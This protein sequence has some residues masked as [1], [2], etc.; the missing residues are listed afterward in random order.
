MGVALE[1]APEEGA[2]RAQDH[3]VRV[4]LIVLARQGH[5]E[6]LTLVPNITK[7]DAYVA[8][9]VVPFQAKLFGRHFDKVSSLI[10]H[11][12]LIHIVLTLLYLV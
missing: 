12:Y 9:E 5:V 4:N 11:F 1:D 10:A 2:A 8:L 7:C 3:F 6:K